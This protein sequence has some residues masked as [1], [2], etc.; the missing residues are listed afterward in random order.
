MDK[1]GGNVTRVTNSSAI[2]IASVWLPRMRGVEISEA[3]A[4]FP[5][6][7]ET[8]EDYNVQQITARSRS[9]V[10]KIE[11]NMGSGS[12]FIIDS[13]GKILTNNHVIVDAEEITVYLDDGTTY[14]AEIFS[15]DLV[16]DIAIIVIEASDLPFLEI[17]DL[18]EVELGQQ[19]VVLGYPL[20]K[21]N[22]AVTSGLVS[23][24]EY[25]SGRNITWVQTDSAINPGNSGGP[26]LTLQGRVVCVV[27]SK[28]VGISVEGVGYAISANTLKMYLP[29]LLNGETI[30]Q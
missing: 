29:R 1:D 7:T 27:S 10:V 3:L 6:L 21:D 12:G 14:E 15:R 19:V 2:D 23:A 17:G 26:I 20:D 4:V 9:A 24:I 13:E 8:L 16:H 25:D 28:L 30:M 5:D 11:T 18:G 22:L